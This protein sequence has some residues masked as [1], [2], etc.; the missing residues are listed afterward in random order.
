MCQMC[1]EESAKRY[2]KI[3]L[4]ETINSLEQFEDNDPEPETN[5]SPNL[6]DIPG[7]LSIIHKQ[8]RLMRSA[9]IELYYDKDQ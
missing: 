6:I 1:S 4:E 2:R 7:E 3:W 5:P 8:V 9:I